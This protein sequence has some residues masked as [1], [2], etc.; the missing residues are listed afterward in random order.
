[1][2]E[3]RTMSLVFLH[4]AVVFFFFIL[5]GFNVCMLFFRGFFCIKMKVS[6]HYCDLEISIEKNDIP[7]RLVQH[8]VH[9][10]IMKSLLI[11]AEYTVVE[12]L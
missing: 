10:R 2:R 7:W 11:T 9:G 6:I 8:Y 12:W 3:I 1:M 4:K 5:G